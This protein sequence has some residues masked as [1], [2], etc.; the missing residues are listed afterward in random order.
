M[1]ALSG[2]AAD[3]PSHHRLVLDCS[4]EHIA[5]WRRG[6]GWRRAGGVQGLHRAHLLAGQGER[7]NSARA[8]K[9]SV[10]RA[11]SAPV[12]IGRDH[13]DTGSVASTGAETEAMIRRLGRDRRLGDSST[14]WHS[15]HGVGSGLG[16]VPSRR[17]GVGIGNSLH[18]GQVSRGGWIGVGGAAGSSA[19]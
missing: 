15:T 8:L 6:S 11:R 1:V 10:R 18:A 16:G 7:R 3:L 13:L 4:P 14:P 9:R 12:V 5:A 19:C 2:D 17:V